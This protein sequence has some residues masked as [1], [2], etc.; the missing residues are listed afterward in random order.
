MC[1][2]AYGTFICYLAKFDGLLIDNCDG[3]RCFA[4]TVLKFSG[5][6]I[7][8]HAVFASFEAWG[9]AVG[10]EL[11][12]TCELMEQALGL[13]TSVI[14]GKSLVDGRETQDVF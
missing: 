3:V 6:V 7:N 12:C 4:G 10:Q 13:Y 11:I 8:A 5:C 9:C 1:L 14:R 2:G